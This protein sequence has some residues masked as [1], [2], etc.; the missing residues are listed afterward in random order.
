MTEPTSATPPTTG[1]SPLLSRTGTHC[2]FGA[3]TEDMKTKVDPETA[4]R[5]RQLSVAGG[6]DVSGQLREYV[7]WLVHGKQFTDLCIE[8]LQRRRLNLMP[9]GHVRVPIG[10]SL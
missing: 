9:E 7:Y 1:E 2:P 6:R 3:L 10:A 5:F 8:D 4:E